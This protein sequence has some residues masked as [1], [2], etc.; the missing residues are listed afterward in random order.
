MLGFYIIIMGSVIFRGIAYCSSPISIII[1][2]LWFLL[3]L[4]TCIASDTSVLLIILYAYILLFFLTV[5]AVFY[6]KDIILLY[7]PFCVG[8]TWGARLVL[9]MV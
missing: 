1:N 2:I 5:I 3:G 6:T 8:I 9:D 4:V 7:G